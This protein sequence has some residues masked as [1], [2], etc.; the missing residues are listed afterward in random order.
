MVW[1]SCSLPLGRMDQSRW[2]GWWSRDQ[3][4][5]TEELEDRVV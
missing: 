4:P 2:D 5:D 3:Y 1:T